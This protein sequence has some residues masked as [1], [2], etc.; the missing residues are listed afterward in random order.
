MWSA[1]ICPLASRSTFPK[2]SHR[3]TIFPDQTFGKALATLP[4][5]LAPKIFIDNYFEIVNS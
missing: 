4:I 1:R 5:I 3:E 2:M